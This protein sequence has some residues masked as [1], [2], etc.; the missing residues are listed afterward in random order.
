MWI[1]TE[2]V[3][4]WWE[5]ERLLKNAMKIAENV[6]FVENSN[7]TIGS[8]EAA[9]SGCSGNPQENTHSRVLL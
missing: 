5:S 4:G 1:I 3:K 8:I 2:R 9:I 7:F 6:G